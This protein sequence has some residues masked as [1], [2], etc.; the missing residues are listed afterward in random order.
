MKLREKDGEEGSYEGSNSA[1]PHVRRE[2]REASAKVHNCARGKGLK[3][4]KDAFPCLANEHTGAA[5]TNYRG[6][7]GIGAI[8]EEASSSLSLSLCLSS[9]SLVL[10][11]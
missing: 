3:R 11:P 4:A 9:L 1:A 5:L 7:C 10:W 6:D 2:R 8:E